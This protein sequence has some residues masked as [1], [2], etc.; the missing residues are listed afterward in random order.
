[1]SKGKLFFLAIVMVCFFCSS[2]NTIPKVLIIGD[3]ISIG[4]TP[5]V[6]EALKDKAEVLHH[7]GNAKY[8][9]NGLEKINVW[10]GDTQ[11]DVIQ[12]NWGLWDLCYRHAESKE[13]GKRDKINGVSTTSLADYQSNL[14]SLVIRLKQT[15]A[16]L[17]FVTTT[18]VP[19]QEAGRF[20]ADVDKYNAVALEIMSKHKITVNDLNATSHKIHPKYGL[21]NDDVHYTKEGYKKLSEPIIKLLRKQLK[22]L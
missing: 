1:M 6:K 12:F 5:F 16:R 15:G 22:D 4:Y 3:S 18:M 8:T 17:I 21:G 10:L 13:Q 11:W 20:S 7:E 19:D 14:D 2:K 9:G